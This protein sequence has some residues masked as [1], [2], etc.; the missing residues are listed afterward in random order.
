MDILKAEIAAKKRKAADQGDA[1]ESYKYTRRAEEE[2][3]REEEYRA[4]EAEKKAARIEQMKAQERRRE[5]TK[6]G[7]CSVTEKGK[8]SLMYG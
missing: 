3:K 8:D 6:V 5:R 2:R 1:G 4:R 7:A